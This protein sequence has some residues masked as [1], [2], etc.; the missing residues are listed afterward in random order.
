MIKMGIIGFGFMGHEHANMM[1]R[2]DE[3]Q[4]ISVCDT[5][6][7]QLADA[8][9]GVET[10]TSADEL[11]AN[12]DVDTVIISVPNTLHLEMV[13][14][15]AAAGKN[16]ICEKPAAMTV[17]EFDRMVEAAEKAGVHMTIHQQRRWDVD[18]RTMK[19]V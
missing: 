7:E 3:I 1:A 14:K 13:Q 8:T 4:L 10:Y 11:L 17:A 18:Y 2:L 5:C 19:A 12:S 6:P 9:E 15:C 16:I